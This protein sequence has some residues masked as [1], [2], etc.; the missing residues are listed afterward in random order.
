MAKIADT[1]A[2][3]RERKSLQIQGAATLV[4]LHGVAS[5]ESDV[6]LDF[7]RQIG[8]VATGAG[9]TIWMARYADGLEV[10]GPNVAGNQA[11]VE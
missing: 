3:S 10:A 11:A 2:A 1:V 5:A 8:E 9:A 6:R 4:N 7:S